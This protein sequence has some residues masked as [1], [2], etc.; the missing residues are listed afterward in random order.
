MA[1]S[2]LPILLKVTGAVTGASGVALWLK[3]GYDIKR[4][5]DRIKRAG[6]LYGQERETLEAHAVR[7]NEL[8]NVLGTHQQQSLHDVVER[9][10][11]FLRRH[12]KQVTENERLLVDGLDSTPGRVTL[13]RGLGLDAVSWVR[14]IVGS[15]IT[16]VG[17]N[18]GIANAVTTFA[19]A[20]TGTA[21]SSLSGAAANNAT[22]AALGG[23]SL[24]SGGGGMAAGAVALNF[25]TIGPAILV[26]GLM[27]AGQG[28]KAKTKARD[29][30]AKLSVAIA[31][32]QATKVKFDA[33]DSRV[34]ELETLLGQ[35]VARGASALDLLESEPFDP[36]RHAARFQRALTLTLAVRDVAQTPVVDESGYLNQQTATFKIRYRPLVKEVEDV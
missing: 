36:D 23:G 22:L 21:I 5:N 11:V 31:E 27:V 14:G 32:M 15:A 4:A 29:N 16:G 9:M 33:I 25:V 30:E 35:L 18:T 8:L 20:S 2:Q 1:R 24:A 17:I 7:T 13:D 10:A 19:S 26:N 12:E 6:E 28:E 34:A 3:G